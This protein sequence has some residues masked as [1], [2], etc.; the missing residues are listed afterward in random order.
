MGEHAMPRARCL[1]CQRIVKVDIPTGV[2]LYSVHNKLPGVPWR[3]LG[4][5]TPV[6]KTAYVRGSL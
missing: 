5:E 1:I 4:S 2:H 6:P 3:C